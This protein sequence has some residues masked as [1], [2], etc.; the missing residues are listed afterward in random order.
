MNRYMKIVYYF[1]Q[2]ILKKCSSPSEVNSWF[3]YAVSDE[4]TIFSR[5]IDPSERV[6]FIFFSI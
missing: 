3:S 4:F 2:I 1:I 6:L 5:K